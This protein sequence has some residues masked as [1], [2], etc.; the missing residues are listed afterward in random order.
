MEFEW[1]PRKDKANEQKHGLGFR[2]AATLFGDPLAINFPDLDHSEFEQRYLTLGL[3]LRARLLV[4]A[5]TETEK[6][7]R[8][9]SAREVTRLERK[10]YEENH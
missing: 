7:I 6:I 2:E 3:S 4:V 5:H 9:I 10:F 8:I 1:D